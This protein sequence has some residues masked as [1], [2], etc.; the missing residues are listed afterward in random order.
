M[1]QEREAATLFRFAGSG[2]EFGFGFGFGGEARKAIPDQ[3]PAFHREAVGVHRRPQEIGI[4]SVGAQVIE[5]RLI[6][7]GPIP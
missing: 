7:I 5:E 2:F 3:S 4:E 6:A 1:S